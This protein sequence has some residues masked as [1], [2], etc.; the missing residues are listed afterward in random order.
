MSSAL[1][2]PA[3]FFSLRTSLRFTSLLEL[4]TDVISRCPGWE[5]LSLGAFYACGKHPFPGVPATVVAQVLAS[6]YGLVTLPGE[7]FLP[8][9]EKDGCRWLRFA[10]A[11][12][13]EDDVRGVEARLNALK[14][15]DFEGLEQ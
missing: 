6:K 5:I 8:A 14:E 3:L 2:C 11:N 7:F 12:V 15:E 13:G 4:F 10:V 1:I 9:E